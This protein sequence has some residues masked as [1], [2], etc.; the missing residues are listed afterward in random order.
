[1]A[2]IRK[3]IRIPESHFKMMDILIESKTGVCYAECVRVAL[4]RLISRDLKVLKDYESKIDGI[5][6]GTKEK[7]IKQKKLDEYF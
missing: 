3:T 5:E 7:E 6:P 1:V 4:D 2:R